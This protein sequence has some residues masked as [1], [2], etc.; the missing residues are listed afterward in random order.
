MEIVPSEKPPGKILIKDPRSYLRDLY[1]IHKTNNGFEV[2]LPGG[3]NAK[4]ETIFGSRT[5]TFAT[6]EEAERAVE[7]SEEAT[8]IRFEMMS[9]E[10]NYTENFF[11]I[12]RTEDGKFRVTLP[13]LIESKTGFYVGTTSK[14]FASWNEARDHFLKFREK[15]KKLSS[16][17]LLVIQTG[18]NETI[19][20]S[21]YDAFNPIVPPAEN[22]HPIPDSIKTYLMAN[23]RLDGTEPSASTYQETIKENLWE[24][25]LFLF[26]SSYLE[27]EGAQTAKELGIKNLDALTPKQAVEL[28]SRIVI[29]L[30]KYKWSD[31]ATEENVMSHE[32]TVADKTSVQQLLQDGL[33]KK[34]DPSWEG[35]GVCRNFASS[36]KAVFEA[37][38]ANQTKFSQLRDTY[39]LFEQ[40]IGEFATKRKDADK[41]KTDIET[42]ITGHSW[43]TF[44]TISEGAAN[45]TIVDATWAKRDLQ[46][47][48]IVNLDHTLLRMEPIVYAVGNKISE[49]IDNGSQIEHFLSYYTTMLEGSRAASKTEIAFFTTRA[50]ELM[51]IHGAPK[52]LPEAL[53]KAIREEYQKIAGKVDKS[54]IETIFSIAQ[55]N[56]DVDFR[57]ILKIYLK[58]KPLSNY[59][60]NSLV[61]ANDQLQN[62]AFEVMKSDKDFEKFLKESPKF[63]IRMR[64]AM[65]KLFFD[66]S[67]G[68]KPE[69]ALELQFMVSR[70]QKLDRFE[71]MI[72]PN[73]P[74]ESRINKFFEK[75]RQ[76]L[77]ATNPEKFETIAAGLDN[78]QMI[79]QFDRLEKELKGE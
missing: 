35:N 75:V 38:K 28:T 61:F 48:R 57:S 29:D 78:Y 23:G 63:R 50:V 52:N 47:R 10:K 18:K 3:F 46:T 49:E 34:D 45:A 2:N 41:I 13:G 77:Q 32:K 56:P 60:V 37:L 26:V 7:Q 22:S 73:N 21:Q 55:T 36:V 5:E 65:P 8:R 1:D 4:T 16:N 11:R 9:L 79:K 14:E 64:E 39:C 71:S 17:P 27:H 51:R 15:E 58:E 33:R 42:N 70:S 74:S 69:D 53:T 67:P 24:Q 12:N 54:E 25:N 66:F 6:Q 19:A 40:R 44:V 72:D 59:H 43:N 62:M 68:T 30:T 76:L 20:F 31:I